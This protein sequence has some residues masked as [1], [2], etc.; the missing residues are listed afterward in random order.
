MNINILDI[1]IKPLEALL[2]T[3]VNRSSYILSLIL[4]ALKLIRNKPKYIGL[5]LDNKI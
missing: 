3:R 4:K 5:Y 1:W 2:L